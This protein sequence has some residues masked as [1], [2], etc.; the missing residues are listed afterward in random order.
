MSEQWRPVVGYEGWYEVSDEGR[1]RRVAPGNGTQAGRVLNQIWDKGY[2]RVTLSRKG[3]SERRR[4]HRLVAEAFISHRPGN[5]VCHNDGNPANNRVGN[6][7]WDTQ[8]EN[9]RDTLR[10]GRHRSAGLT[11]CKRGHEFTPENTKREGRRR[12]CRACKKLRGAR[13]Y[14]TEH[15]ETA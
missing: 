11:H 7:R 1:V 9:V 5:V 14:G 3:Q 10:H 12:I 8:L 4:V 2:A 15:R 6:L 13:R